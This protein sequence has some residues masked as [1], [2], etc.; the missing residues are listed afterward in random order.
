MGNSQHGNKCASKTLEKWMEAHF[1]CRFGIL[2]ND[3]RGIKMEM[4]F[5][6]VRF[7]PCP[8]SWF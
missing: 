2:S 5:G 6:L 4:T 8:G 1:F 7:M 3:R